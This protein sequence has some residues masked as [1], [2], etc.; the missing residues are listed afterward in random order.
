MRFLI[1]LGVAVVCGLV[2]MEVS[3]WF[4]GVLVES[5]ALWLNDCLYSAEA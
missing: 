5:A 1:G 3:G 4:I 2:A